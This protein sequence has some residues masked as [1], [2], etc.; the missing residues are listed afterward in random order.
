MPKVTPDIYEESKESSIVGTPALNRSNEEAVPESIISNF[1]RG[2]SDIETLNFRE[3]QR[4]KKIKDL[5]LDKDEMY[6]YLLKPY[7]CD[8]DNDFD[9]FQQK[10]NFTYIC[11]YPECDKKFTK[12]WNALDHMR[13]H[14]GIRPYKCQH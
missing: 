9:E 3:L 13:M 2:T 7:H 12:A 14:E 8:R 5:D 11:K 6:Y 4:E 1:D 10:N